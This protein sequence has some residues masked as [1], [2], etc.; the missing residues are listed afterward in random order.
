MELPLGGPAL[1]HYTQSRP[2]PH[3]QKLNYRPNRLQETIFESENEVLELIGRVDEGVEEFFTKRVLPADTLKE[4]VE[5][6]IAVQE[7]APA[8]AIPCP[9]PTKTLRK[10]LGDFFTLKKRRG[11]K[12]ET[13]HE[14]RPKK[15]SIADFIRPLREV[16][17]AEKE[18]DKERV[19]EN[20]K[21]NEKEKGK[22]LHGGVAQEL[23]L[24]EMPVAGA[25]L[26][27]SETVPPRRALRE[28]KSQSLILLSGSSATG[29]ANA[30]NIA[31]KQY[32]GQHSFEQKLHIMLQRIGVSKAQPEA[33][34]QEGEMKKAESEGT[35]ID[36]KPEPPPTFTKPRTMSA[37]SDI[38]HPIRTSVSAHESAGKPALPPKPLI[39]PGPPPTTSG[40]ST[41]ENE[42]AQIQEGEANMPPKSSS[43]PT[44]SAPAPSPVSASLSDTE[45]TVS[46]LTTN[47]AEFTVSPSS[48]VAPMDTD[49]CMDSFNPSTAATPHMNV[50]KLND[51]PYAPE[52]SGVTNVLPSCTFPK[53]LPTSTTPTTSPSCV[54]VT[55]TS[56]DL[57]KP[58]ISVTSSS[59]T[60]TS[61]SI[62]TQ[63][64]VSTTETNGLIQ[65][66]L[67]EPNDTVSVDTTDSSDVTISLTAT[68]GTASSATTSISNKLSGSSG[69]TSSVTLVSDNS[70]SVSVTSGNS[71]T[72]T[73]SAT[74]ASSPP[75]KSNDTDDTT[76]SAVLPDGPVTTSYSFPTLAAFL[77]NSASSSTANRAS[78]VY[79]TSVSTSILVHPQSSVD[80]V[81]PSMSSSEIHQAETASTT[82]S[83]T[84]TTAISQMLAAEPD[85]HTL[86]NFSTNVTLMISELPTGDSRN[87]LIEGTKDEFQASPEIISN[88]EP[89]VNCE[90][91]E[92]DGVQNIKHT[93][94]EE[95]RCDTDSEKEVKIENEESTLINSEVEMKV[96]PEECKKSDEDAKEAGMDEAASGTVLQDQN[97]E[98][99]KLG[100]TE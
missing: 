53:T 97:Q 16:T 48:T 54:S 24:Q 61:P 52:D 95:S 64:S 98:E 10:K 15:T 80:I 77:P 74:N 23:N 58:S 51:K 67:P 84:T 43:P 35:I 32:D 27:R 33:Q 96:V 31:K 85:Q 93:E 44:L 38:R 63:E 82:T 28:G 100:G 69:T 70:S 2:R 90:D 30:R 20:D 79:M 49:I 66:C 71:A 18:K 68:A 41:P 22:D 25:A 7:V 91:G 72:I 39:K 92:I 14:G 83:S 1:R 37:S 11:L 46:N 73:S 26:L 36:S 4:T 13:S 21:E 29:N 62:T 88:L 78:T 6:S 19:K 55:D 8:S 99:R 65:S 50:T 86:N 81:V 56:S 42:V 57:N 34:N 59:T 75:L 5:E 94:N 47:S 76:A 17:R 9:P 40:G 89:A 12:S 87:Y 45:L 60:I 3:R